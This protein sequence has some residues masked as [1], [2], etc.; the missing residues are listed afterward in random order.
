MSDIETRQDIELLVNTFYDKV[1][2]DE[3]I[4]F[5]FQ[6]IIGADWSQHLPIM[7]AFWETI[8]LHKAGYTGNPVKK[9]IDID[10][11][12]PLQEEHYTR[13]VALWT[14]T[15]NSLFTGVNADE[16]KNRASLMMN[17]ISIKVQMARQ[18][19]TIM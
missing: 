14:A 13:W 8:I 9:H 6:Q 15:V 19:K 1:K 7:Y 5:I 18:G 16:I 17:L 4:G 2:Q 11:K 12:I 3:T 10:Q